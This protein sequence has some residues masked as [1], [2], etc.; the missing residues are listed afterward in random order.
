MW[1]FRPSEKLPC[2]SSVA[3]S[4]QDV[5][6]ADAARLYKLDGS[7]GTLLWSKMAHTAGLVGSFSPSLGVR[8]SAQANKTIAVV[9]TA[10]RL[11]AFDAADGA[12]LWTVA[13]DQDHPFDGS[14]S[15]LADG[16]VAFVTGSW[17]GSANGGV[18]AVDT[19]TGQ[20][21]W[22]FEVPLKDPTQTGHTIWAKPLVWNDT[23]LVVGDFGG[24]L[25]A[26]DTGTGKQL[27]RFQEAQDPSGVYAN[28]IWAEV[29]VNPR[30]ELI[31]TSN[32]GWIRKFDP[33]TGAQLTDGQ[34][35][36]SPARRANASSTRPL[37]GD[38]IIFSAPLIDAG[39]TV[40]ISAE[41][42]CVYAFSADGASK[43]SNCDF[44]SWGTAGMILLRD[45]T[46]LFGADLPSEGRTTCPAWKSGCQP[47]GGLAGKEGHIIALNKTTGKRL[48]AADI[49]GM[50][51]F[52][53]DEQMMN[54]LDDGT[55]VI[56]GGTHGGGVFA[57]KGDSVLD[58]SAPTAKYG[59]DQMLTGAK[60][61][62]T[63]GPGGRHGG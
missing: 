47:A 58:P 9:P 50:N 26:F 16:S 5:F 41:N 37:R 22:T 48:W 60:L 28:E 30:D 19:A 39:G 40:Y 38:P 43:W 51:T 7:T 33:A 56:S 36:I 8:R 49:P 61:E 46:L 17:G 23:A 34:W 21:R 62:R 12:L 59:F 20:V 27:W 10:T 13:A 52:V 31:F 55:I 24:R 54:V 32:L 3:V 29:A 25:Y 57:F 45:G 6:V 4:G 18:V 14:A 63:R 42:W 44:C 35:P 53:C 15:F 11:M 2:E 1:T